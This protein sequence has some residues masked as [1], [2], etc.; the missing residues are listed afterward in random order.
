LAGVRCGSEDRVGGWAD[1]VEPRTGVLRGEV[2]L[3][4]DSSGQQGGGE[5]DAMQER[6]MLHGMMLKFTPTST[7][8]ELA[9]D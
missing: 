3:A 9:P 5:K 7:W 1:G 8:L 6:W 4:E 2:A